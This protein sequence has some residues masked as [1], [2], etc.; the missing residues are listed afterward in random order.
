MSYEIMIA[1][2]QGPDCE[3]DELIDVSKVIEAVESF[4]PFAARG[5]T[6]EDQNWEGMPEFA[7]LYMLLN[8][9]APDETPGG[10][11][12]YRSGVAESCSMHLAARGYDLGRC[13]ELAAHIARR[14]GARAWDLQTEMEITYE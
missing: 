5:V 7:G 10:E 9:H 1:H 6:W 8:N 11:F 3:P 14:T 4:P 13:Y 2:A 12:D